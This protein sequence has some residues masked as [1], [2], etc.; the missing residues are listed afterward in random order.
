M[1]EHMTPPEQRRDHGQSPWL[2]TISRLP[3]RDDTFQAL[4]D[5]VIHRA[6]PTRDEARVGVA[7]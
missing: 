5:R 2:D 6:T 4:L 1:T 3:L 7:R